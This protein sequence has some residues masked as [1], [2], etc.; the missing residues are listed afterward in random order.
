MLAAVGWWFGS[1]S[2]PSA[3]GPIKPLTTYRG[4]E[5]E[6]ALSP[7]GSQVAFSWDGENGDNFDIYVRLVDGG[8]VLRL[9]TDAAPDFAPAW[10]PDSRRLA[11]LRGNAVYIIPA[12]GGIERKLVQFPQ[13]RIS[14]PGTFPLYDVRISWSP[15]GKLLA[16]GGANSNGPS[17]IW[18][19][20]TEG[21]EPRPVTTADPRSGGGQVGDSSPVFSPDGTEIAFIRARY[22]QPCGPY[23]ENG[24]RHSDRK[25]PRNHG[26]RALD[27]TCCLG[28]GRSI[29]HC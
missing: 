17:V 13:G 27:R 12:L 24:C 4:Y 8:S 1:H 16:F 20:P 2:E 25:T 15:D 29:A 18:I 9:T 6:P 11:F 19:V 23:T 7:D 5:R 14:P 22:L 10:S 26:L 28:G 3:P 21:G